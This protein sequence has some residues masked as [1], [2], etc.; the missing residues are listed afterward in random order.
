MALGADRRMLM[1]LVLRDVA[2]IITAGVTVGAAISLTVTGLARKIL[3]G[4][5]PSDPLAF[6]TAAAVLVATPPTWLRQAAGPP[7]TS[8]MIDWSA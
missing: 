2:V 5:T 7:L 3:F 1:R 8:R 6:V 4:V